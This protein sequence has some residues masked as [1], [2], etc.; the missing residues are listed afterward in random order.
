MDTS[1]DIK[2][3]DGER[4]RVNHTFIDRAN[5]ILWKVQGNRGK[6]CGNLR[7]ALDIVKNQKGEAG[8]VVFLHRFP[9]KSSTSC[10]SCGTD[11]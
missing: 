10:G 4:I 3:V 1:Q 8:A 5:V 2:V 6:K 11:R 9:E 7:N